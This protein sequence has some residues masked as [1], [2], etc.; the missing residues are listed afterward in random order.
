[1]GS[2]STML[3]LGAMVSVLV[4]LVLGIVTMARGGEFYKK[5]GNKIMVARVVLQGIA[6][7]LVAALLMMKK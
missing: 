4:V 6:I 3:V 7:A 5:H 1:M 2:A